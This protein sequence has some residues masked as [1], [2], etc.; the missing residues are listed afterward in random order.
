MTCRCS[1]CTACTSWLGRLA[2]DH[3][4]RL[5]AIARREGASPTDALDLVQDAFGTLLARPDAEQLRRRPDADGARVL[6]AIVRNAARNLRRRHHHARPH[7]ELDDAVLVADDRSRP[8]DRV[9]RHRRGA[10]L[11]ACL[12]ELG[13]VHRD[14]VRLRVLEEL[15]GSDAARELGLTPGHVAVLLHR[16]REQLSRCMARET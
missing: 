5:I 4:S 6:G 11:A 9:D 14:V 1:D 10:R 3:A 8:D 7:V 12:T 15:S 2:H 13:E 16:A